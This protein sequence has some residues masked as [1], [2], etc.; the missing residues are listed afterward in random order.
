MKRARFHLYGPLRDF[1]PREQRHGIV[2]LAFRGPQTVKHLVESLGVPHPEV[3][4]IEVQGRGPVSWK[5]LV[6][7]GETVHVYPYRPG[8]AWPFPHPPRFVADGHLGRL[9]AYLR[10]MGFDTLY[11]AAWE[12]PQL[13]HLAAAE[14]RILLTRD[15]GLLKRNQVRFG[16]WLRALRPEEQ[17]REVVRYFQLQRW[18][19]PFRRCAK[20]N[21]PLEDVA[22]EQVAHRLP[23]YIR[24]HHH[25]FRHCPQCQRVYWAGSH[26]TR[27]QALFQRVL[28]EAAQG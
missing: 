16:Y 12:D 9:T 2:E 4:R 14:E 26:V 13:A 5:H 28:D 22:K 1:L 23:E 21:T 3:A 25:H 11:N 15:Q 19:Q 24:L 10:L 6:E 17:L 18:V 27:L 7:D 20:C 8:E